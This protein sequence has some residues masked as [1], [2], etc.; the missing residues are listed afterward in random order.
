MAGGEGTGA[1]TQTTRAR[2]P[3]TQDTGSQPL[4]LSGPWGQGAWP[5][6]PGCFLR[7]GRDPEK[8]P[9]S[10]S[11][12]PAPA[13][14]QTNRKCQAVPLHPG[15]WEGSPWG[16]RASGPAGLLWPREGPSPRG[17]SVSRS[18]VTGPG[19]TQLCHLL[20]CVTSG[21]WLPPSEAQLSPL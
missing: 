10:P 8:P 21:R 7:V 20:F 12:G 3:G 1:R 4:C 18:V 9:A 6:G 2:R 11:W 5:L 17:F 16:S 13:P 19:Q 14:A 15:P